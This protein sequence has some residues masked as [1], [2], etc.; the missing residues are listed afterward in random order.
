MFKKL[1]I[2]STVLALSS[3]VAFAASYKGDYKGEAAPAPCPTYVFGTGPYVGL[4]VGPI[5]NVTGTPRAYIG[6]NG[7]LSAGYSM[8]MNPMWYLA[9]E[10]FVQDS[11]KL[12]DYTGVS[13]S[14]V[15]SSWGY[16]IDILPGY[17]I[18]DHTLG[19]GRLGAIRSRFSDQGQNATGWQIGVGMQTALA[20]NWDLRGEYVYSQYASVTGIGKPQSHEVN[21][22]VVYKFL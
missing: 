9:G 10:I 4:S 3:S 22:G 8:M 13:G 11:A 17:M 19:Y 14:G 2:A 5:V 21:A 7:T 16:G 12:K 6:L 18:N 20:Q 15:R 1:L